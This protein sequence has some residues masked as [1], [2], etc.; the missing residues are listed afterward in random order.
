[1]SLTEEMT[2]LAK[3]ARA[4]SRRLTSLSN[5]DKNKC[6]LAMANAIEANATSI[7]QANAKDMAAGVVLGLAKPMLDR[8]LLNE[9]RIA[10]M[11][12]G[13][14]EVAGLP[15]PVGRV[16]E[17]RTR[18]NGL[19]LSKVAAPIGVIVIIYESRPNVTADAASLCFKSG[20]ATILRGGKEAIHSNQV[21][22][23]IMTEAAINKLPAFPA[24]AVQVVPTTDRAAIPEL[25]SLTRDVDLCIPRGGES[26]IRAV[27]ECS[28]VPVIKHYKGVCH[29]YIDGAADPAMAEEIVFNSKVHRPGVCNAAETLLID[30]T[31]AAESLPRLAKRLAGAN[32]ELRGDEES[33][34]LLDGSDVEVKAAT[35][36][37]WDEEY[38]DL[39]LS[40]KV[41]DGV[42]DAIEHINKYGSGHTEAIVT[43]DKSTAKR[44]QVEVDSSTIFW[45]AS[46]RFT[47][48]GQFG[49]GAEIGISTDKIGARGPM[50]LEE[51]TSYKWLGVADGLIRP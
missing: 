35:D 47:D 25:L 24:D 15:D 16:I 6:L 31:I 30:Q 45:N 49:M 36:A 10:D 32:V 48:G 17:E 8:L 19:K 50:G 21:I 14:R 26:L 40:V 12:T 29:V 43:G 1:M 34:R 38:L 22:A 39:V 42:C 37:D 27:A 7:Q 51:L 20:N 46:T 5:D 13:L 33:L 23:E 11:A 41:V 4:A 9:A 3:R 28:Q 18:P 44:F 2:S